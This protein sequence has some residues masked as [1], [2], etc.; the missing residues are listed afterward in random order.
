MKIYSTLGI[1]IISALL[2]GCGGSK[3]LS[4]EE[5]QERNIRQLVSTLK[6]KCRIA[7]SDMAKY[8]SKTKFTLIEH[9]QLDLDHEDSKLTYPEHPH[10]LMYAVRVEMMNGFGAMIPYTGLCSVN[11]NDVARTYQITD[12]LLQ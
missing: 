12:L 6:S 9:H 2:V 7:I 1:I 10:R 5:I 11:F 8:P 4:P 3:S